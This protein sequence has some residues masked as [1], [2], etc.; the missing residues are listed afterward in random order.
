MVCLYLSPPLPFTSLL[1]FLFLLP[2]P[3]ASPP[4]F[5]LI[6]LSSYTHRYTHVHVHTHTY[7][8]LSLKPGLENSVMIWWLYS[9]IE[10]TLSIYLLSLSHQCHTFL[11]LNKIA[12]FLFFIILSKSPRLQTFT[13]FQRVKKCSR[14]ALNFFLSWVIICHGPRQVIL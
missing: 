7:T 13:V 11:Q 9:R 10:L 12:G 5:S 2:C 14:V 1:L 6:D 8:H 4:S 3:S